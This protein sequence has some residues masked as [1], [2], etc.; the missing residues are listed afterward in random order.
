MEKVAGGDSMMKA[1][2]NLELLS[3]YVQLP[4]VCSEQSIGVDFLPTPTPKK[5]ED[6]TLE[7]TALQEKTKE[8]ALPKIDSEIDNAKIKKPEKKPSVE[9]HKPNN[10]D[11]PSAGS[12]SLSARN[13]M[14]LW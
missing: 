7:V 5:V 10:D 4:A 8:A 14:R 6:I 2:H 9:V 11:V 12:D 1:V 3:Q 13:Q